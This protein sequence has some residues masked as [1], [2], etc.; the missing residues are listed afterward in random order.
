M[1][2][3]V[4]RGYRGEPDMPGMVRVIN[5]AFHADGIGEHETLD[6]F[7]T[8]YAHL[9]N[10][11]PERDVLVAEIDGEIV[12]YG[13]VLW[14]D[15]HD[16]PRR[17]V[18]LCFL[19][20]AVRGRGIGTAMYHHNETLLRRIA[21]DHPNDRERSFIVFYPDS[22]PGAA[23][24]YAD[25]GYQ[26]FR[27]DA[28]MIR[29]DLV[30]IPDAP[31]PEGLVVRTP[32]EDEMREVWDAD[33]EAFADHIGEPLRT[34][35]DYVKF[36]SDPHRDPTL[37]R[38]AWDGDEVA[39]QVRSF[40]NADEN[41]AHGRKRGYTEY[42]SVRRPY[43]QRGLARALLVQSL[44]ALKDRGMEEAALGVMTENRHGAH[45]LYES[46]G[47]RIAMLWTQAV[48]PID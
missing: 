26:P 43:R 46:V 17:Y 31:M 48:K 35:N 5:A 4:F 30:G 29:P 13:R 25:A 38:I 24:L 45:R 15:E 28:D 8:H 44:H 22:D 37:W 11:D 39:G 6:G 36:L 41:E 47:F 9:D 42:I 40:I 34:E 3:L 19:D 12:G 7:R 16:G 14:W 20:P 18:P 27:Y 10:T 32:H 2:G 33:V 1:P 23:A 21:A